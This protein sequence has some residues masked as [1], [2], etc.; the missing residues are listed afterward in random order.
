MSRKKARVKLPTPERDR[1][2]ILT[3]VPKLRKIKPSKRGK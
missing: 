1:R 3:R 2:E